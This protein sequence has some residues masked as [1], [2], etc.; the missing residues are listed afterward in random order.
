MFNISLI[1]LLIYISLWTKDPRPHLD[2]SG[3]GRERFELEG[4][5]EDIQ[6]ITFND[7]DMVEFY[8]DDITRFK[9]LQKLQFKT[10]QLTRIIESQESIELT[11]VKYV[12]LK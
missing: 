1:K 7:N 4:I 11:N 6:S 2:C 5:Q 3:K 10:N 12:F 9:E 8:L